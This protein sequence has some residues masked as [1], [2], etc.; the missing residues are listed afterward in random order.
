MVIHRA[1]VHPAGMT[2]NPYR[3]IY[4]IVKNTP[5]FQVMR[6]CRLIY[7]SNTLGDARRV[8]EE[9]ERAIQ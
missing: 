6:G 1:T 5:V 8:A 4:D 3:L 2:T 7:E 9:L